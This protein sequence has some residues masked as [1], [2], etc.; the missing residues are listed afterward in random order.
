[1][2]L[3]LLLLRV[4][5]AALL[6]SFLA[7]ILIMLWRDLRRETEDQMATRPEGRLV[8]IHPQESAAAAG[9][10]IPLQPV[11]S[12]GRAPDNTVCIQDQFASAHHALLIWRE[13]QWWLEDRDSRNGT[14]L[15][16][17]RIHGPTVVCSGDVIEVGRTKFR[18]E[19]G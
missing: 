3:L 4:L 2:E 11:T 5:L 16:G 8:P 18:L 9:S 10:P 19:L 13:K 17:E 15:N 12:L 7:A 1:M 14:L 6:Y